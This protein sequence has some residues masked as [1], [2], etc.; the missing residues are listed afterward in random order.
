MKNIISL[1][2][3]DPRRIKGFKRETIFGLGGA[4]LDAI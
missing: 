2:N 1:S 3:P 4:K